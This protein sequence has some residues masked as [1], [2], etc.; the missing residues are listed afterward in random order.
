[1]QCS[2]PDPILHLHAGM[3]LS[4]LRKALVA[5]LVMIAA[6]FTLLALDQCGQCPD[7][8][9]RQAMD[10]L[11]GLYWAQEYRVGWRGEV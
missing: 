1:V 8:S 11:R 6:M 7:A 2:V 3:S 10:R 9:W 4:G 5:G